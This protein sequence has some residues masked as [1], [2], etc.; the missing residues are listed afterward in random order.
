[1]LAVQNTSVEKDMLILDSSSSRHLVN[2]VDLLL[3]FTSKIYENGEDFVS[4]SVAADGGE[5]SITKRGT[6]MIC[7]TVMGRPVKVRLTGIYYAKNVE[8]NIIPYSL[9]EAK[10]YDI[11][12]R[13]DY[14][15]IAGMN[16]GPAV[17]DVEVSNNVSLFLY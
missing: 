4:E 16:R 7:V 1:M 8:R 10:N 9:L 5:L 11:S 3:Y 13:G 17:F 12:Y 2:D 14:R 15:V 6:A